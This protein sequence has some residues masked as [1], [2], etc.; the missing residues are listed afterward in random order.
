MSTA[1]VGK[2]RTAPIVKLT[3]AADIYSLAKT[4]YVLF[5]GES[6]R[7]FSNA[8]ISDLPQSIIQQPW[9]NGLIMVLRKATQSNP[10][11]RYQTVNEFWSDL[12]LIKLLGE[13]P[14]E[15]TETR[16]S[17]REEAAHA[18][19]QPSVSKDFSPVAPA[20]PKFDTSRELKYRNGTL[21]ENNPRLV[22]KL[23]ENGGGALSNQQGEIVQPSPQ[24]RLPIEAVDGS[25]GVSDKPTHR[26]A[27]K[28]FARPMR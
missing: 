22:V 25:V 10:A 16:V 6:P 20:L 5:T 24:P 9:A 2:C 4:A 3:P 15:E 8:A 27:L 17:R 12:G 14:V 11:D 28:R 1:D 13:I 21:E 18:L 19:P 26:A 23:N 7:R